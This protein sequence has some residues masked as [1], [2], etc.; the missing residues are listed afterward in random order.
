MTLFIFSLYHDEIHSR[1]KGTV[2]G[3]PGWPL[4]DHV[5]P[6]LGVLEYK[7]HVGHKAYFKK[8]MIVITF[9]CTFQW[10]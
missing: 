8:I 3:A 1:L 9:K 4:V 6:D 5:T 2:L 10:Q 7:L